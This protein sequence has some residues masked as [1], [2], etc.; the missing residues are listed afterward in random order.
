MTATSAA[1]Q[2]RPGGARGCASSRPLA[3]RACVRN[4]FTVPIRTRGLITAR[5]TAGGGKSV[6]WPSSAVQVLYEV[7][8]LHPR[9]RRPSRP[10]RRTDAP[11]SPPTPVSARRA[12]PIRRA[13]RHLTL[14]GRRLRRA[15]GARRGCRARGSSHSGVMPR[16]PNGASSRRCEAAR[17][18]D[19]LSSSAAT[20][21]A[22]S[23]SLAPAAPNAGTTPLPVGTC[24]SG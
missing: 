19:T 16:A 9:R 15:P 10:T 1:R 22:R 2:A 7:A 17:S 13:T 20:R 24:G 4:A 3:L 18:G 23:P 14:P 12:R 8:A 11:C 5:A 6:D 21:L